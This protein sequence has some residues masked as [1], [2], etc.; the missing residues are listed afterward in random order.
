MISTYTTLVLI[1]DLPLISMEVIP[2]YENTRFEPFDNRSITSNVS[3]IESQYICI[4]QCFTNSL[5]KTATYNGYYRYCIL[6]SASLQEGQLR[7]M[8]IESKSTVFNLRNMTSF[9]NDQHV[10][11]NLFFALMRRLSFVV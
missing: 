1:Y 6:D 4:C 3:S 2:T 5:C 11:L 9:G 10:S 8:T 7:I